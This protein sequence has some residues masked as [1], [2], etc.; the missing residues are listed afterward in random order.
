MYT[1]EVF[2][3]VNFNRKISLLNIVLIK[4]EYS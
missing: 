4:L 1:V 3:V 2:E